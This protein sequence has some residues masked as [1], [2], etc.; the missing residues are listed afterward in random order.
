M[1]L[2]DRGSA[3]GCLL[4]ARILWFHIYMPRVLP[5]LFLAFPLIAGSPVFNGSFDNPKSWSVVRGIGFPDPSMQ[6]DHHKAIVLQPL[7]TSDAYVTSAPVKLTIGKRYEVSAYVRTEKLEV[8]DTGRT[9]IE[10]GAAISMASMPWDVHSES[11]GGTHD[12]ARIQFRF[13]GYARR[14]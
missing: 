5:W 8:S 13:V 11:V 14:R 4:L 1:E 7:E 12:W 10:V 3:G 2:H 6:H 9:P